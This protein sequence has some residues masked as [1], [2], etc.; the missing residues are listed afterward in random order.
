MVERDWD[1]HYTSDWNTTHVSRNPFVDS[2]SL[3]DLGRWMWW[4]INLI[5]IDTSVPNLPLYYL[6]FRGTS[7][8]RGQNEELN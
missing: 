6:A 4:Y 8:D 3:A 7:P 1:G 2:L 5:R